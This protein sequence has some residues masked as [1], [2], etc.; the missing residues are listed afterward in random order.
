MIQDSTY[1]NASLLVATSTSA[2]QKAVQSNEE[3]IAQ[4]VASTTEASSSTTSS[5]NALDIYA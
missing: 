5:S 1:G 2:L 4:L 3:M